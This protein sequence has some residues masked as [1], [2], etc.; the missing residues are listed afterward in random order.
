MDWL[1]H[2]T[3]NRALD[4][5]AGAAAIEI[6]VSGIELMCE[7][8]PLRI[9]Y[10]GGDF[11]CRF[12]GKRLPS[13]AVLCLEPGDSVSVKAGSW[14]A[15]IYVA[16]SGGVDVPP[17]LGSRSTHTKSRIGGFEGR[18]LAAGDVLRPLR[19]AT[20]A[21]RGGVEAVIAAPWLEPSSESIRVILGPQ[22]DYFEASSIQALLEESFSLAA[23]FDRMA[24]WLNGPLLKHS[25]GFN[26]VSD[27][28]ALGAIQVLGSGQPIVLMADRQST[29]GY[30]KIA[31]VIRAD[32]S[33]I[34]Q[35]RPGEQL[36]FERCDPDQAQE[37]LLEVHAKLDAFANVLM[38]AGSLDSEFLLT[39]NLI[40]GVNRAVQ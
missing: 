24:Y 40:S 37:I 29:G 11:V 1:A 25:S 12:N 36:R 26:I 7:V 3:A 30:P 5:E 8:A 38:P 20:P 13:A 18:A 10:A 35:K 15:W 21:R 27:G 14:G 34:A 16:A 28:I 17:I 23:R 2:T 6:S 32:V 39:C 9:A 4:N 33:R 31:N 19:A 22:D